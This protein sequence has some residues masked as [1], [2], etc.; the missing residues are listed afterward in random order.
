MLSPFLI[1]AGSVRILPVCHY[2]VEFAQLVHAAVAECAFDAIAV[3]LPAA[4]ESVA[5]EAADRLPFLSVASYSP[6]GAP[7]DGPR[8]YLLAEPGDPILEAIRQG[9]ER[10]VPVHCVDANLFDYP[11][12]DDAL[13]DP[14]SVMRI[15]HRR[16]FEEVDRER[17]ALETPSGADEFRE[18]IMAYRLAELA[19]DGALVLFV[20]GMAHATRIARRIAEA[21][22]TPF[23]HPAPPGDVIDRTSVHLFNLHE[24][25]SREVLS[26][27]PFLSAAYERAR[28]NRRTDRTA[29]DERPSPR[30]ISFASR[31]RLET[32][33]LQALAPPPDEPR[34]QLPI[35]RQTTTFDLYKAAVARYTEDTG[36]RVGPTE[37]RT[38][39]KFLRNWALVRGRLQPD[40]YQIVVAARGVVDDNYAYEVWDLATFYPWQDQSGALPSLR[41]RIEDLYSSSRV[42]RFNRRMQSRR[43]RPL[44]VPI[45]ERKREKRPGEWAEA[46]DGSAI[47]S[48]PPEDIVVESFGGHLKKKAKSVLS[49]ENSRVEPFT[50]SILDGIDVR[51]TIRNFHEGK[52]FVREHQ[53]LAGEVGSVV[54]IFDE[55]AS[56]AYPW[57]MTWLGE[58]EQESDMALYATNPGETIVGPGISRV[59][60]GG[61]MMTY[62]PRRVADVWGD[63][64][65]RAA[66]TKPEVLLMAAIDYSL[67]RLVVYVAAEPPRTWMKM[68][69]ARFG[70]KIVYLPIGQ[71]SPVTLKKLRVFH[72]LAGYDKRVLAKDYI[73]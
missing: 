64:F 37:L 20:C 42:I 60:Y 59:E 36:D 71:L 35:D 70:K 72:V 28:S 31:R 3:E 45:R 32:E 47:C 62:P 40:F 8:G 21:R 54:V 18:T 6:V 68:F 5:A 51:E 49:E 29:P 11:E 15:G 52:I 69:A 33:L 7:F 24:D 34:P 16:Y 61:F 41:V 14:Y 57:L 53:K 50:T 10:G 30:I 65:Y 67:E 17:F 25:S 66:R 48:Y 27:W 46:F 55:D 19:R 1:S 2:R 58:H 23:G 12:R 38:L 56:D 43:K 44:L 4:L 22:S 9:R 39:M 73:W 13:P 63:P 26:E